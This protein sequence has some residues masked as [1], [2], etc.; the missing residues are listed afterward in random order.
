MARDLALFILR[1]SVGATFIM[2]GYPKLF[3]SGPGGFA[4]LLHNLGFPVPV[5]LAWVVALLVD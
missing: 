1:L 4:G 2:H 3:P 5:F